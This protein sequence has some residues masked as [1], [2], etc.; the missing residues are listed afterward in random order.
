MAFTVGVLALLL[1]SVPN[2]GP[3]VASLLPV[4]LILLQPD[5]SLAWMVLVIVLT[6]IIQLVSGNVI[7]PKLMGNS[8]D[9]H[10]VTVLVALMLWGMVWGVVG[11]FLAT[12]ITAAV[13]ILFSKIE[14]SRPI[15]ELLAG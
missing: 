8:P 1:N 14:A 9:L 3:I 10:P 15:A 2:I 7:E 6:G 13:K 5:A 12:P 4:P 11:M